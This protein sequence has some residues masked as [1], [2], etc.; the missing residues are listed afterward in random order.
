MQLS[1]QGHVAPEERFW[2]SDTTPSTGR[3]I[4]TD[5]FFRWA[6]RMYCVRTAGVTFT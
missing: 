4:H 3:F 1:H 2:G 5:G 6:P